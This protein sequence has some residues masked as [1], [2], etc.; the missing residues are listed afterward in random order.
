MISITGSTVGIRAGVKGVTTYPKLTVGGD[1]TEKITIA[2]QGSDGI[3]A[4]QGHVYLQAKEISISG[5]GWE[6]AT[7]IRAQNNTQDATAP[8]GAAS[9]TLIADTIELYGVNAGI[10]ATSNGQVNITGNT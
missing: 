6:W 7:A 10:V 9:V 8:E 2:G 5:T 4:I 3:Q 1:T